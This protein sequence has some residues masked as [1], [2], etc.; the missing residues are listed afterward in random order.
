MDSLFGTYRLMFGPGGYQWSYSLEDL[1]ANYRLYRRLMSRWR[2]TLG[3]AFVEVT[4]EHLIENPEA[5]IALLLRRCGLPFEAACLA[6][7]AVGGGVSTASAS[8][9]RTP[10]NRQGVGVWRRY[11]RQL[12]PLRAALERDG[13]VDREGEAVWH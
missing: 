2:D 1:A 7:E 6:P 8:Q 10:I 13:F 4:L 3:D 12:E 11:A 5:E 9:V